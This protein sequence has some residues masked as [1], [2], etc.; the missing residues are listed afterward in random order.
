MN[1]RKEN[2]NHIPF[3]IVRNHQKEATPCRRWDDEPDFLRMGWSCSI[4]HAA[5]TPQLHDP[6]FGHVWMFKIY[7][8]VMYQFPCLTGP[9][10]TFTHT[11]VSATLPWQH[12]G[13]TH[14]FTLK[15]SRQKRWGLP[16]LK[17]DPCKKS[18]ELLWEGV[19]LSV[20]ILYFLVLLYVFP[21]ITE[22]HGL[23]LCAAAVSEAAVSFFAKANNVFSINSTDKR[24]KDF[25]TRRSFSL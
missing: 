8:D 14:L 9:F 1:Y 16:C 24:D 13:M 3:V 2:A 19:I 18:S 21:N 22:I 6:W 15:M 5:C 7:V 4:N 10:N 11:A 23:I 25:A 20:L 12:D 17:K